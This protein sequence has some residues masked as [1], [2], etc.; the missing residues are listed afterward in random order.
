MIGTGWLCVMEGRR[1]DGGG[2]VGLK[3]GAL[4]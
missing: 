3:G 1:V 4:G 2:E